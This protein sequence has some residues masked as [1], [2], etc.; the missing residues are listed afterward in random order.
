MNIALLRQLIEAEGG[1]VPLGNLGPDLDTVRTALAELESFGFTIEQHPYLG[2]AYR[3]GAERICPDQIEIDLGTRWVGRRIA[4]WNQVT[5]TNDLAARAATSRANAGLVVLAEQQSA[6][7]GR[8]GR[9][10]SAPPRSSILM[11]VL[12]FPPDMLAETAWLTALGAVAVAEVV[13][14]WSGRNARIK[15]PNDVRVE[16]HKIA[17]VL[18]ERG[19][20]A[21]VGIG[22]N[23]NLTRDELPEELRPLATSL[24]IL[25]GRKVD[26]SE[27]ARDLIRRLDHWY[28]RGQSL[29]PDSLDAPW[30]DRSE[31]L[32]QP[33]RITTPTGASFGR[34]DG[35]GICQGISLTLADGREQTI[36]VRDVLALEAVP[37]EPRVG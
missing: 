9:R 24:Q 34:L 21:V 10:W 37:I 27:L 28:E 1:F 20:G 29:G 16:G 31:H 8:R 25:L 6:G 26:R 2:V 14:E 13:S 7:R 4:V 17:G 11:S 18:V 23:A 3:A 30:R 22:I 32:G 36:A 5:S 12:L 15:W 35:I 33:V 19:Q